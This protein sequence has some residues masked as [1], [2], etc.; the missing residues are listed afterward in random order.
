MGAWG[1]G[2]FENDTALDFAGRIGSLDDIRAALSVETPETPIDAEAASEIVAAA[3]CVA[4]MLGNPADDMPDD[5]LD[6]IKGFGKP[7][8]AL[9][10]NAR[11]HVSAVISRSE[12]AEL[13]VES[14]DAPEFNLAMTDLI[15]RLNPE[16]TPKKGAKRKKKPVFNNSPCAFCNQPMGEAEFSMFDLS[17]DLGDGHPIRLGKWAHLACLNAKLHPNHIVQVWKF[18]PDETADEVNRILGRSGE[19]KAG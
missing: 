8:K 18:D 17:V 13:W 9:F 19:D 12:L 15:D 4:A 11:D 6:R 10:H 2:G 7:D 5:L 16:I 14:G 1:P 3:E